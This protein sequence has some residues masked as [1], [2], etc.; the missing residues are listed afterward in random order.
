MDERV[1]AGLI[2]RAHHFPD[3]PGAAERHRAKA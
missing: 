2:E 3:L 1:G